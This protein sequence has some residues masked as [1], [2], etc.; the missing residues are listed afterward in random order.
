MTDFKSN[1]R[2]SGTDAALQI[3]FYD[4]VSTTVT[5]VALPMICILCPLHYYFGQMRKAHLAGTEPEEIGWV[6]SLSLNNIETGSWLVWVHAVAVWYVV[7]IVELQVFRAMNRFMPI[8]FNWL[9][10][11]KPPRSTTLLVE[12][13]PEE[14][15]SDE[16]LQAF[17]NSL[18]PDVKT[19]V[20]DSAYIVKKI[21]KLIT[22]VEQYMADEIS[23]QK[24]RHDL[25]P[26]GYPDLDE[27]EEQQKQVLKEKEEE[28]LVTMDELA[29]KVEAEQKRVLQVA[30]LPMVMKMDILR[31]EESLR[32]A[33]EAKEVQS[34]SG[35]VSFTCERMALSALTMRIV[36]DGE[37]F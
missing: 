6:S 5:L 28:M 7:L 25:E 22:L 26:F 9:Q 15:C 1:Q 14:Y 31:G 12:N 33:P 35:F 18:F 4:F 29:A 20:V 23:L 8:R 30:S 19:P 32:L 2:T 3:L 21:P 27:E 16:A 13:I 34:T 24:I 37:H 10:D 17:F 36:A 11:L